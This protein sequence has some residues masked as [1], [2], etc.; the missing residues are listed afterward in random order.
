M[1]LDIHTHHL[2]DSPAKAVLNCYPQ[3]FAPAA[4]G[5][6][7]V[8]IHPWHLTEADEALWQRLETALHHPQ[9]LAVG[10]AGL[11]KAIATPM[12]LQQ[13]AFERQARLA[14]EVGKPLIIHLVK[15]VDELL[16]LRQRLRPAVPWIVHG[17]RGKPQ[18]AAQLLRHGLYLSYGEHYHEAAMLATPLDRLFL[19]TD[20][21]RLPIKQLYKR[22]AMLR[23]IDLPTL[24]EAVAKNLRRTGFGC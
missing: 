13:E 2:P 14:E 10:E 11:D 19:E 4:G 1:I 24:H 17:F 3:T 22:A 21:S 16:S 9:V 8:G 18:Q 15:A 6:Y 23:G 7:S 12:P 5:C 20:E